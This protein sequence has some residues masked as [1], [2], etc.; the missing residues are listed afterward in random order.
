MPVQMPDTYEREIRTLENRL[1][2]N[3]ARLQ[4]RMIELDTHEIIGPVWERAKVL[5]HQIRTGDPAIDDLIKKCVDTQAAR[6]EDTWAECH[7][8]IVDLRDA[9][10][11][12]TELL[13]GLRSRQ[14]DL[15]ERAHAKPT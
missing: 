14:A 10:A 12:D 2:R 15:M 8:D 13:E 7:A 11:L 3:Q 6:V 9:I 4:A 5:K 1:R